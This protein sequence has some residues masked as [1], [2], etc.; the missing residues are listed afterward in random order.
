M[1]ALGIIGTIL[2][3]TT[4]HILTQ[5]QL[6]LFAIISVLLPLTL[7]RIKA[8]GGADVKAFMLIA[9]ISP[10]LEFATWDNVFLEAFLAM[11]LQVLIMIALGIVW[12]TKKRDDTERTPL[13]PFLLIGYLVIQ[14]LA[15]L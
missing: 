7:Y 10:G 8:L 1:L 5:L 6:H 12:S 11:S 9:I 14:T 3:I 15:L 2:G 4:G 13:L